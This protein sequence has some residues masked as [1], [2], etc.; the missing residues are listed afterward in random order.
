MRCP[1]PSPNPNPNPHQAP[2]GLEEVL[3]M[4]GCNPMAAPCVP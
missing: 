3:A 4:R 2:P 1:S